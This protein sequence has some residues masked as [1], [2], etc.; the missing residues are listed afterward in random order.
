MPWNQESPMNQ[1]I[2]LVAD[3]LSGNFTKSQLARR[4]DVS[5]P[6]VDKW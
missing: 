3:W 6:T 4:F 5:R 1:R 2:K